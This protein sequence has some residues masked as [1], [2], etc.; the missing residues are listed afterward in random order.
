MEPQVTMEKL[1]RHK[2]RFRKLLVA[3]EK[4]HATAVQKLSTLRSL[5]ILMLRDRAVSLSRIELSFGTG[6]SISVPVATGGLIDL[7]TTVLTK[8]QN[9]SIHALLSN[10][11]LF[12]SFPPPT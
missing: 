12:R 3:E 6:V 2:K 8:L 5:A 11:L 9:S 7:H 4:L 1:W 10:T